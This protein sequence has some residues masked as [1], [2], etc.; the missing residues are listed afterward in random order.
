MTVLRPLDPRLRMGAV[1]LA[2]SDLGRSVDFYARVLGLRVISSGQEGAT[3]GAG[4]ERTLVELTRLA[5]PAPAPEPSTGLFHLALL[6]PERS[7]LADTLKRIVA[8]RWP[9]SGASDHG[10]SE[11]LYLNDPD[12]L[13]IEVY[14]D[15]PRERWTRAPDGTVDMYT[16]PLDIDGLVAQAT[17]QPVPELAEKTVMGHVHLKVSDVQRATGFYRD[18][19][20]MDVQ[21][22][23]PAA[24]FLGAGGYHHHIGANTWLSRGAPPAPLTAPGLR[25]F[26]LLL[27]DT[28]ALEAAAERLQSGAPS[29]LHRDGDHLNVHDPDGNRLV[30]Q[31]T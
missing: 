23:M 24:A 31:A 12:G 16:A 8:A 11:A 15:R 28:G 26:E 20:G 9:L 22:H 13:G 30:L 6:H 17:A 18:A 29:S 19:L 25:L 4:L 5:H 2:V 10:V 27:T 21:A 3:L 14:V 7:A 1:H